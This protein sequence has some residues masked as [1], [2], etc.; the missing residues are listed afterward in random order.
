MAFEMKRKN[1]TEII[2][3]QLIK[4]V[5]EVEKTEMSAMDLSG[6]SVPVFEDLYKWKR[7]QIPADFTRRVAVLTF[8]EIFFNVHNMSNHPT[9][10][11]F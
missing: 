8:L 7:S 9:S 1:K 4:C 11:T 10:S 3:Q 2:H 6:S 5:T